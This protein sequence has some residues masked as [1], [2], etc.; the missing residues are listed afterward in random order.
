MTQWNIE[1]LN[2]T[3]ME[4]IH[5]KTYSDT[6][7]MEAVLVETFDEWRSVIDRTDDVGVEFDFTITEISDYQKFVTAFVTK[8]L[9]DDWEVEDIEPLPSSPHPAGH[10]DYRIEYTG[11]GDTAHVDDVVFL[12][13]KSEGDALRRSQVEWILENVGRGVDIWVMWVSSE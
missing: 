5:D 2:I 9:G 1:I 12:E 7:L 3:E 4:K 10:P 8:L 11:G 6:E 13:F